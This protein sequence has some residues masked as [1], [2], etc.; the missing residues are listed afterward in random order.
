MICFTA[1]GIPKVNRSD[2]FFADRQKLAY[3]NLFEKV[4]C[5]YCGYANDLM[6]YAGEIAGRT[7]QYWC[8]IKHAGKALSPHSRYNRFFEY[9]DSDGFRKDAGKVSTDFEDLKKD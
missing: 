4:N 9:G 6:A 5:L 7:E 2:Y 8:P 1:Y 3:L